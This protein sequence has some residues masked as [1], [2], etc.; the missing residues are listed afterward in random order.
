MCRLRWSVGGPCAA[1]PATRKRSRVRRVR[2][3]HDHCADQERTR[4]SSDTQ[5]DRT[6]AQ[7]RTGL[8]QVID[9]NTHMT[10]RRRRRWR[11]RSAWTAPRPAGGCRPVGAGWSRRGR[12]GRAGPGDAARRSG[13]PCRR[14]RCQARAHAARPERRGGPGGRRRG[15]LGVAYRLGLP[16]GAVAAGPA[17]A[18]DNLEQASD[19][20]LGKRF[21]RRRWGYQILRA[22]ASA[23]SS[24]IGMSCFA[25]IVPSIC[26]DMWKPKSSA[27]SFFHG[28]L[29]G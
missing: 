10:Q 3:I 20:R 13:R 4:R 15:R 25:P 19:Q 9:R 24:R 21:P 28:E 5:G 2:T 29:P 12:A 16:G 17:A 23:M 26:C 8:R 1:E 11:C 18:L 7:A 6:P 14:T 22:F 27:T